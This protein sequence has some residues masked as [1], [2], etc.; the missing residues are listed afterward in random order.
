MFVLMPIAVMAFVAGDNKAKDVEVEYLVNG[1]VYIGEG[2]SKKPYENMRAVVVFGTYFPNTAEVLRNLD[3]VAGKYASTGLKIVALSPEPQAA[4]E[5]FLASAGKFEH[6][7]VARDP[8]GKATNAYLEG[9]VLTPRG[10]IISAGRRVYWDGAPDDIELVLESMFAGKFDATK[11][12]EISTMQTDL[13]HAIAGGDIPLVSRIA[14]SILSADPNNSLAIRAYVI[15]A[16]MSSKPIQ[17]IYDYFNTLWQKNPKN[18]KIP[19]TMLDL[20]AQST[21]LNSKISKLALDFAAGFPERHDENIRVAWGLLMNNS[22]QFDAAALAAAGK[23]LAGVAD[24]ERSSMWYT[25]QARYKSRVGDIAAA[26]ELQKRAAEIAVGDDEKAYLI[27][28][29][30]YYTAVIEYSQNQK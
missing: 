16:E 27:G 1:P 17:E 18:Y 6:L 28:I 30:E 20:A 24:A 19:L 14:A 11:A 26:A 3:R 5:A 13:Q 23:I 9:A 4:I 12:I 8:E 2:S 10:F 29:A 15:A 25:A 22:L 7:A 21:E